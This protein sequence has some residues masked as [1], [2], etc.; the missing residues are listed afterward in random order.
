MTLKSLLLPAFFAAMI[1]VS[2]VQAQADA[3]ASRTV[4]IDRDALS[5]QAGAEAALAAIHAAAR[6]ACRA[7]NRGGAAYELGLRLC[8][9]D[10]VARTVHLLDAPRL[11]ALL[12][13]VETRARLASVQ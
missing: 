2:P 9:E 8:I 13:G 10:S 3:P 6:T 1:T 7:E 5:T 12:E 4:Q 11:T